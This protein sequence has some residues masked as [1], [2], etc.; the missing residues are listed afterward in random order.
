MDAPII[1]PTDLLARNPWVQRRKLTVADY[2]RMGDAGIFA[3]RER[4]EL[5]EGELVAMA[6]IGSEH[7]GAVTGFAHRLIMAVGDRALVRVQSPIRLDTLNEP[8]PDFALVKPRSDFYRHAHPTPQDALL[9]IEVSHSSLR[10]DRSVKLALYAHHGIPEV[11]IVDVAAGEVEVW[12]SPAGDGYASSST[13]GRDG[14]LRP[15]A[16]PGLEIALAGLL[17]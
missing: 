10:Y 14:V 3:D 15:V 11:W 1:E 17:D 9:L 8:K 12:S 16:L 13:V 4:V 5:I 6:P 7:A 2:H